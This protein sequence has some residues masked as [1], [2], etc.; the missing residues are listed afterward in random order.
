MSIIRGYSKKY[1]PLLF[2]L[3]V[4]LL[5]QLACSQSTPAPQPT[6]PPAPA[7]TQD[8]AGTAIAISSTSE[9]ESS[10]KMELKGTEQS[11]QLQGTQ[12][13]LQ[14]TQVAMQTQPTQVPPTQAPPPTEAPQIQPTVPLLSPT[15]GEKDYSEKIKNAKILLYEDTSSLGIGQWIEETLDRMGLKYTSTQDYSGDFMKYLDSGTKWD[16]IIIGAENHS[17]IQ[18]EFWD[19]I[20]EKAGQKV[21]IISEV[22]YLDQ[23]GGG[24]IRNFMDKCG[25]SYESNW[26]LAESIYWV[27]PDHEVFNNPNTVLPLLHYNRY[28]QA[29]AGDKVRLRSS[30]DAEIVAGISKK[31]SHDGG[32]VAVCMGGRTVFQ[33][34]CN[35][36]FRQDEVKDLWENYIT[37]TLT[38]H[39]KALDSGG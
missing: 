27:K 39:F 6:Q 33:T 15:P 30:G 31:S 16:L 36:D 5:V 4:I 19:V 17:V 8:V 20:L 34:F 35:H 2:A 7:P 21:A 14:M 10:A 13:A 28:W 24:K 18:G 11:L 12:I 23:V 32:L 22:W 9:A 29:N 1:Q 3:I 38:N 26:D 37:Y 25:I